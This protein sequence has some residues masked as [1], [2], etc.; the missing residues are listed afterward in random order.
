LVYHLLPYLP[1]GFTY[2]FHYSFSLS[3]FVFLVS[4]HT[5]FFLCHV[6]ISLLRFRLSFYAG[7]FPYRFLSLSSLHIGRKTKLWESPSV[8]FFFLYRFLSIPVSFSAASLYRKKDETDGESLCFVFLPI[9]VS[10][11]A[12]SSFLSI[13]FVFLPIAVSFYTGFF[14]CRLLI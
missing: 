9:V 12:V 7:F 10:F 6:F 4:S 13:R 11:S 1:C 2:H 5:G 3:S 14:L 8:S